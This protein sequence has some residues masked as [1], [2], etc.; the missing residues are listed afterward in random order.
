[1]PARDGTWQSLGFGRT[2]PRAALRGVAIGSAALALAVAAFLVV[3]RLTGALADPLP[4]APLVATALVALAWVW[5]VRLAWTRSTPGDANI[6]ASY[7]RLLPRWAPLVVLVLLAAACS[8]PG[9]RPV[10]WIVW[11]LVMAASWWWPRR[12]ESPAI[13]PLAASAP[14]VSQPTLPRSEQ[15]LQQLSRFRTADGNETVSG[16]LVAEFAPGE[17]T[18]TLHAAFCPPFERLPHVAAEADDDAATVKVSQVLHHGVRLDV[19]L[20][21]PADRQHDVSVELLATETRA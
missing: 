9:G 7:E 14:L 6:S 12:Y 8:Y 19:R 5:G 4:V 10:D 21:R 11:L 2:V 20:A 3:R 15:L 18:V 1:M 13:R 17:R 16:T